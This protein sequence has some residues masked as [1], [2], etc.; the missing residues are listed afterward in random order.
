[1]N[2]DIVAGPGHLWGA[3][4]LTARTWAPEDR[5]GASPRGPR[6]SRSGPG[7][8]DTGVAGEQ[9]GGEQQ[10]GAGRGAGG[11]RSRRAE[12][13]PGRGSAVRSR[14]RR[15]PC[16]FP[17]EQHLGRRPLAH[18]GSCLSQPPCPQPEQLS[19]T[20]S[21][22]VPVF[23][24]SLCPR[25]AYALTYP[26]PRAPLPEPLTPSPARPIGQRSPTLLAPG[27]SAPVS[28]CRL[29]MVI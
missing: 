28:T 27:T 8:R 16:G 19:G 23:C 6:S 5:H 22:F 3:V 4:W 7:L 24:V 29:V 11:E 2:S 20:G 10:E 21:I 18:V 17:F 26:D 9:R 12:G 15:C 14:T 1:M 25:D 13:E